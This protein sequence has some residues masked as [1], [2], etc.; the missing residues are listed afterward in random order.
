MRTSGLAI[1]PQWLGSHSRLEMADYI[2]DQVYINLTQTFRPQYILCETSEKPCKDLAKSMYEQGY[3]CSNKMMRDFF[4]TYMNSPGATVKSTV[5]K[6]DGRKIVKSGCSCHHRQAPSLR[7]IDML[8]E[9]D[10]FM[11]IEERFRDVTSCSTTAC[12]FN[13][14]KRWSLAERRLHPLPRFEKTCRS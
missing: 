8:K 6:E 2:D 4:R 7:A 1:N 9:E 11:R 13:M 10:G 12:L 14:L 5:A 3:H